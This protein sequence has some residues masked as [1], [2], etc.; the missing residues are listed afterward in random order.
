MEFEEPNALLRFEGD[1]VIRFEGV[2]V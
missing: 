1:K 2:K